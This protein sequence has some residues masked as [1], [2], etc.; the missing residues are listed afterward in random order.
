MEHPGRL[1]QQLARCISA[2]GTHFSGW[3]LAALG[4]H[5][6]PWCRAWRG[7]STWYVRRCMT[8]GRP[9]FCSAHQP[10]D[11]NLGLPR[12]REPR[13]SLPNRPCQCLNL[14]ISSRHH[15]QVSS[16]PSLFF[17]SFFTAFFLCFF[18]ALISALWLCVVSQSSHRL[19]IQA[20][21]SP[22]LPSRFSR[23]QAFCWL[24]PPPSSA[25]PP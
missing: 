18:A 17:F 5:P 9:A 11:R 14:H 15:R 25:K 2:G 20:Y 7:A 12:P 6:P 3:P 1:L 8:N 23:S 22:V 21:A 19:I 4:H 16:F 10:I 24:R 13:P